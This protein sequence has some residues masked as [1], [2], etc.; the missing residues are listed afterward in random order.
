[1]KEKAFLPLKKSSKFNNRPLWALKQM[2][3][4]KISILTTILM[5]ANLLFAQIINIPADYPTI[6]LGIDAAGN[7]DTV[8]VHP[9]TYEEDLYIDQ[10]NITLASLFLTTHDTSYISQ[11]VIC[12]T[13]VDS[14]DNARLC[15]FT[16]SSPAGVGGLL[17]DG[18]SAIIDHLIITGNNTGGVTI[19]FCS[20]DIQFSNVTISN[21]T[22]D[23]AGVSIW[24]C[25]GNIRFSNVMISNNTNCIYG[26]GGVDISGCS[27]DL[28]F[29]NVTFSNNTSEGEGGGV[30]CSN[31]S[32]VFENCLFLNNNASYGGAVF[33]YH[34]SSPIF[35]NVVFAGNNMES[36]GDGSVLFMNGYN[37]NA[38]P[39]FPSLINCT[40]TGNH[41]FFSFYGSESL[42]N[43]DDSSNATVV[44]SISWYNNYDM[45]RLYH[46]T[47]SYSNVGGN[48][49]GTGNI[50]EDPLFE[51]AGDHPC[52]ITSGSPCI[53]AGTPDTTG[54]NLP[55][56][57]LI[58]NFRI[59]DGDGDGVERIDMGAY[60]FDAPVFV[61]IRQP[62]IAKPVSRM[63]IFPNPFSD[64]LTIEFHLQTPGMV[65]VA[66]YN[67]LGQK[68]AVL[69]EKQ[70]PAG[71]HL[72]PCSAGDLRPGIYLLLLQAGEEV[73]V[74][75]VIRQ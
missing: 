50:N 61:G 64:H 65:S 9:G 72:I 30:C 46:S 4:K 29:T 75:K 60:E 43:G 58:G 3:M 74:Q 36:G 26:A 16:L 71:E 48:Q 67:H 23:G 7:G 10:K 19:W 55:L 63:L 5:T 68:Q 17:C 54:L 49:A 35:R 62:K 20:G 51:G 33:C 22:N 40:I 28:R 39:C 11:T 45:N 15:G 42:I 44:N 14:C 6:Q 8:L 34:G 32:P 37:S 47:V 69:F 12:K 56:T 21:N 38:D 52:Q 31:S 1:L 25:S 18:T 13:D 24:N 73:V 57:D 41:A 27:G 70:L 66:L 2:L 59:W 53:D